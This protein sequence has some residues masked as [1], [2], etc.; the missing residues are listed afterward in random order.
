[1]A[2]MGGKT[3]MLIEQLEWFTTDCGTS[4]NPGCMDPEAND[5]NEDAT[6]DDGVVHLRFRSNSWLHR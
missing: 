2:S 6:A 3:K 1:M 5:Y 4:H